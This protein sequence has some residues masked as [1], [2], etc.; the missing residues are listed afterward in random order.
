MLHISTMNDLWLKQQIITYCFILKKKKNKQGILSLACYLHTAQLCFFQ[1]HD[2]DKCQ[3]YISR[4]HVS[5]GNLFSS[6][7]LLLEKTPQ[8]VMA[9]WR[10]TLGGTTYIFTFF[11]KAIII[12]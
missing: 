10:T 1:I 3:I 5:V 8:V 6:D 4:T 9:L 2:R 11:F 12:Q 7:S